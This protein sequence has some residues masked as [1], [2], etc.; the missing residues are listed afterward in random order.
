MADEE[1]RRRVPFAFLQD[2]KER[3]KQLYGERAKTAIAFSMNEDFSRVLQK[4]MHHFNNNG[5]GDNIERVQ[6][7]LVANRLHF[8]TRS[9][10]ITHT[11]TP[12]RATA[13][14]PQHTHCPPPHL[15]S[16]S[17]MSGR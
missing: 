5:A 8:E 4:R 17:T 9:L 6:S 2:I 3:F 1:F 10:I 11:N 13:N 12:L 7:V 16:R 15:G 14:T